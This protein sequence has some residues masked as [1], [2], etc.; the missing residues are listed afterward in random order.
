MTGAITAERGDIEPI[1]KPYVLV[2]L[3]LLGTPC[4]YHGCT[5]R[6]GHRIGHPDRIKKLRKRY[7]ILPLCPE[8]LGGLPTP[9]PPCKVTKDGKVI[10]AHAVDRTMEYT[11]GAEEC[12][13]LAKLF[14]V[15]RAYLLKDSPACG[16]DYGVL[17]KL[18]AKNRV[19]IIKV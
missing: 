8:Q 10:D 7:S 19:T 6:M 15:K 14:D 9:R 4:R 11:R 3:C 12:L 1:S 2:S 16:K 17:A 18:L 5:H 13:R